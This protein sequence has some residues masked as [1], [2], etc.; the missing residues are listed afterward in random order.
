[1]R[2]LG[3]YLIVCSFSWAALAQ[4]TQV[5]E[6]LI[7]GASANAY[8]GDLGDAFDKWASSAH[9]GFKFNMKKR[10]NG[11]INLSIGN[12]TGQEV[13]YAFEGNSSVPP[14]PNTFF[15]TRIFSVNYEFQYNLIKHG[16]WIV[17]LSQGIGFLSFNP[18]NQFSQDLSDIPKT[19]APGETFSNTSIF[20]PS[21]LGAVYLFKNGFGFELKTGLMNTTTDYLDNISQWGNEGGN[22]NILMVKFSVYAPLSFLTKKP[23]L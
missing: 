9:I 22:D 21:Q 5:K 23:S 3:L 4:S 18:K 19:R 6:F 17:Y 8:N 20:F 12:I 1:M 15:K 11:S 13:D 2:G 14:T 10:F 7:I 16:P